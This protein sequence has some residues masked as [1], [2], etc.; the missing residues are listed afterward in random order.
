MYQY[1]MYYNEM[2]GRGPTEV[3]VYWGYVSRPFAIDGPGGRIRVLAVPMLHQKQGEERRGEEVV[4]RARRLVQA[5][6]S[7][8]YSTAM[9][10][11]FSL[12]S[13]I[14]TDDDGIARRDYRRPNTDRDIATLRFEETVLPVDI[15]VSAHGTWSAARGGIVVGEALGSMVTVQPGGPEKLK[16]IP[17][18]HSFGCGV[19]SAT[20]LTA[21]GAAL[22]WFARTKL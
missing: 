7:F 15:Q 21:L 22:I 20:V 9:G 11:V 10:S 13:D 16:G 19:V 8:E 18:G 5:T 1:K 14:F 3:P 2:T 17:V 12:V 6:T 4:E